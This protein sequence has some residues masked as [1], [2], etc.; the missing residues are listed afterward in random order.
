VSAL[1]SI[2]AQSAAPAASPADNLNLG[3][4]REDTV[5]VGAVQPAGT[6]AVRG[7]DVRL[8]GVAPRAGMRSLRI[9]S[10]G[11]GN[12]EAFGVATQFVPAG[13][14]RGRTIRL[15]G[16]I[17]T[18]GVTTGYA[19]LW[20]RVDGRDSMLALEN[21]KQQ[22]LRWH[23]AVGSEYEGNAAGRQHRDANRLR[24]AAPW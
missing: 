24:R 21:M 10:L 22:G 1:R 11:D 13:P 15:R 12:S 9:R 4:E 16:S 17:R 5:L 8:D 3:F 23:H 2:T 19:G 14:V 6:S 20:L 7:I 18:E